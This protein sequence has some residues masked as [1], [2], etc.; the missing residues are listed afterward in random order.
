MLTNSTRPY[1]SMSMVSAVVIQPL[2]ARQSWSETL[3]VLSVVYYMRLGLAV[4]SLAVRSGLM[5][6]WEG[7]I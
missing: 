3:A 7:A 2:H 5:H 1:V 4:K 6:S